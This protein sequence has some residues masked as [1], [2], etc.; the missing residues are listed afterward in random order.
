MTSRRIAIA[1]LLP[2]LLLLAAA[3][4]GDGVET[5]EW[6]ADITSADSN[7]TVVEAADAEVTYGWNHLTGQTVIDGAT[8]DVEMLGNVSY[9][10]GE[11]SIFGFITLTFPTGDTLSLEMD[12]DAE[13]PGAST[14]TEFTST[15]TV[16]GGTGAYAGATGDGEWSG[17]RDQEIGTAVHVDAE[18]NVT[19]D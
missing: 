16:L 10:D 2:L 12:G 4:G 13:I 1:A 6:S 8:V 5:L 11:G 15:I 7:I 17:Y 14:R 3:C 18:I 9:S 19:V